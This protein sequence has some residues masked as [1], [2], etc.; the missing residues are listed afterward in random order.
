MLDHWTN[1]TADGMEPKKKSFFATEQNQERVIKARQTYREKIKQIQV[2]DLVFLDETGS[3]LAM[4]RSHG[5]AKV[6]QRVRYEKPCNRGKNLTILGSITEEGMRT[7]TSFLGG[8]TKERMVSFLKEKLLPTLHP[9]KVVVMDNLKA[10]H[11]KE[12]KDLFCDSSIGLLY[13]PPYCPEENPIEMSWSKGK[14]KVKGVEARTYESL[15]EAWKEALSHISKTDA[16]HFFAH[17]GYS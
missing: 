17:C 15:G 12:V 9:G 14:Q 1:Q 8:T 11:A 16:Q 10:H 13:L 3:N 7:W 4:T 2:Q 5:Y 6:G